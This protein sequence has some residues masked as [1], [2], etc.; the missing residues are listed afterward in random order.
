[1]KQQPLLTASQISY[2]SLELA[3]LLHT[4]VAPAD[5]LVLLAEE[6]EPELR[7]LLEQMSRCAD[8]GAPLSAAMEQAGRWP[9][10]V[11]G[12]VQV[13]EQTGR[14][15]EALRSLAAYYQDRD[16]MAR[17]VRSAL[18]YPAL[19]FALMLGVVVVLLVWVLPV[20]RDVYASLGGQM[21]GLA[22]ALL[23]LGA[24]LGRALPVLLVLAAAAIGAGLAA[25]FL[26]AFRA[27]VRTFWNQHW[28]DKGVARQLNDAKLAQALSMGLH[29]GLDAAEALEL[30]S[31]LAGDVPAAGA[32]YADC[33]SRLEEGAD[34]AAALRAA[35]VLPAAECRL[36]ALGLRSG[37]ADTVMEQVAQRLSQRSEDALS[38]AVG[39]VEP[40][41]VLVASGMVGAILLSVMLPLTQIMTAIG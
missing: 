19:L 6:A 32:R 23:A 10:Y 8:E 7:P 33:R 36:L 16:R 30:A 27:R 28:G 2:L 11:T 5:G 14:L 35:G 13:G 39:R 22:G 3:L 20:F 37:T 9:V 31:R 18:G 12:L 17:Q 38:A 25:A 21:T 34:L 40:A 24:G 4:G 15:E 1:M 26:P 41:L 29:S